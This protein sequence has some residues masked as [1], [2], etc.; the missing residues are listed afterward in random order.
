M[1]WN[2]NKYF[3]GAKTF[4]SEKCKSEYLATQKKPSASTGSS[5]GKGGSPLKKILFGM[6]ALLC[7]Y[8]IISFFTKTEQKTQDTNTSKPVE[9]ISQNP[10]NDVD[11]RQKE[12]QK[13]VEESIDEEDIPESMWTRSFYSG[14]LSGGGKTYPITMA[15][16]YPGDGEFGCPIIGSYQY[17]G[18]DD[19][20]GL[21]GDWI[22]LSDLYEQYPILYSDEYLERFDLEM[23]GEDLMSSTVLK[24]SWSKYNNKRDYDNADNPKTKLDVELKLQQ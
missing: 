3:S 9:A 7:L 1:T 15:I 5:G 16:S 4:C 10:A 22:E 21:E 17:K 8:F 2:Q 18:H 20:I 11:S 6:I 14:T 12:Y 23:D 24:G 19:F 13:Q